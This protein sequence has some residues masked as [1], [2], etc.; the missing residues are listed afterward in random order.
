MS[1]C[2]IRGTS[3]PD[4]LAGTS[5]DDVICGL[6]GDD[7]LRGGGGK[8]TLFGGAG[9]DRLIGAAG[10]DHL[11]GGPGDDELSGGAGD[12]NLRGGNGADQFHG[13][14][15][16]D[17]G[18]YV[19]SDEAVRLSLG[20]GA[21]DGEPG[22]RDHIRSDVENLRGGSGNDTLR[23]DSRGNWLQGSPG[24]DRLTGGEGN[25]RLNGGAGADRL[26]GRDSGAFSDRLLCGS[27]GDQA[28]ADTD[29]RVGSD[30]E[31]VEQNRAPTDIVLSTASVPENEP[32]A[33]TVG[34]LSASD[35]NPGDTH[36]Y[37]LVAGVGDGDNGS[38]TVAGSALRTTAVFDFE[39]KRSYSLRVRVTDGEGA[40]FEKG[41]TVAVTDR[42]ENLSPVAVDD[43]AAATED[44]QLTLPLSGPGSPAANDTDADSNPLTVSAI[45]GA[46]GGNASIASGQIQF[47]PV[48]NLCGSGAAGFD[49]T[50]SDGQGGTDVGRVAVTIGCTPDDPIAVDDTATVAEDAAATTIDVL[51][52][53]SDPDGEPVTI[54]T[55]VQPANGTVVIT[56]LGADL[57]YLP[58]G[59]FCGA[60]S[61]TYTVVGGVTATVD[62]AV[63]CVNDAPVVTGATVSLAENSANGTAVHTVTFTDVEA[64]QGTFAI[65]SGDPDSAFAIDLSTGAI[66]VADSTELDFETTPSFNLT[67]QVTDD[68]TPPELGTATITVNL[69]DTGEPP[70]V[71]PATF[72]VAENAAAG[73]AVGSVT[74]TDPDAG[75]SHTFAITAGNTGGAFAINPTSGAITVA[76]PPNFEATP[77]YSLTVEVTDD[78]TPAPLSG[79]ATIT[80]NVTNVNEAPS[81][82]APTTVP[83]LRDVALVV[84]GIS[85]ADP[86]VG[87]IELT[88]AVDNGTIDVDETASTATVTGD[89]T[90]TIVITGTVTEINAILADANGVTYLNNAGFLGAT[91]SLH[92]DVDDLGTPPLAASATVT[93]QFNQPPVAA[94]L[95]PT[96]NEDTPVVVT[97]I[98]TDGDDDD[99]TF[100]ITDGPDNGSL[101]P[102]G[103]VDCTTVAN[104][105]T[106]PVTYTPNDD[107]NGADQFTY[108]V[109]DGVNTDT[110]TVNITVNSVNDV[111]VITLSGST[112]SYTENGASAAVDD[113]LTVADADDTNLVSGTVSVTAG[114]VAG[115]TLTFTPTG[116]IIDT[117]AAPDVLA[118][119][120][121]A[122]VADWQSVLRSIQFSSPSDNPT[123]ATRT[124]SFVVNDGDANS[125]TAQKSVAVVPV[126]DAAAI[127]T[128][129]GMLAYT[130][131]DAATVIDGGLTVADPDD[132][133]LEAARVLIS[134]GFDAGDTLVFVNQ[135]GITGVYNSAT[136]LLALTGTATVAQYQTALRSVAFRSTND[137]PTTTKTVEF[138]ADDGDGLGPPATRNIDVT[139]VND[140][141]AI[142][143]T[144]GNVA[145]TENAGPVAIDAGITV[146]DPDSA[147][148]AGATVTI[149]APG[150]SS[151]QDELDFTDQNGIT[152]TYNDTTG[153][154]T[155]SGT[156]SVANYQTA[157]RSVTYENV[158]DSPSASRT[159]SFQATDG[160]ATSNAATRGIAITSVND[161]PTAANDTASTDE[162]TI[163]NVTAPG[164]LANDTDVD[165]GDTKTVDRLNGNVVLTG[166]SAKGAAVTI[167]ANGS[168]SYNPGNIFQG[169]STGQSDTDS[170]TYRMS[171]SG[172]ASSTATVNLTII[173]VSDAPVAGADSFDGIGNTALSVGTARPTGEAGKVITGSVLTN[174][175]DV[176]T[177][178]A[179]LVAEAVTNAPTTLGGTITVE[180]DGNFTYH[181]DDGDTGVT[182]TFTYRVCD[183]T[184]CNSATV[185]NSTGTLSLPLAGQ[186][187]YVQNN[188]PAGGDGTS[189]TPFDTIG[190]AET[191]SGAG[192]TVYVFDGNNTS[193][194]LDTGFV[195]EAN[196][197]LIGE[198]NGVSLSGFLLHPGTA[199]AHPTLAASGEDVVVLA[200][201]ATVDG[202][203][204]D[205]A[206]AG[207][208][209][210]S[211]AL[212][213]VTGSTIND[214]NVADAGPTFGSQPGLDLDTTLGTFNISDLT[215]N[216]NGGTGV[217]LNAASIVNFT[218]ASTITITTAG[219][220]G[221]DVTNT[222]LGIS[223]FDN[224]TVT[225]SGSGGVSISGAAGST[226]TFQNLS[227]TTTSGTAPAFSLSSAG[228]VSVPGAGTANLSATGG[229]AVNVTGTA[230]AQ[231]A[232]DAVNSTNSTGAGINIAG[233]GAG[234]FT[235]TSGTIAGA[236]GIAF[237]LDGGSGT[238]TYPGPINDGTG[239]SADITNRSGGTVTLSGAITDGNDAGGGINL[240][241][242]TG[243]TINFTGGLTL[244]TGASLALAATA[245]GTVNVCA[246]N[247]CGGATAVVNTL[248]TTTGTALS[249]QNT[250]IGA[251][252]LTFRSISAGTAANAPANGIVLNS[253]GSAGGLTVT[254]NGGACTPGTPTCTGGTI[255]NTT[256]ADDSGATPPGTGVVLNNTQQ[257]SLT[258]MRVRQNTNYAIRG[259]DVTGFSFANGLID[260]VNGT[261]VATPFNDGSINLDRV[262][263]AISITGSDI[264]GGFQRNIKIDH[265]ATDASAT[266]TITIT[267]NS[268]HDTSASFGDDGI[269]I[270]AENADNY[271][272]NVSNNTFARHGGDHINVTMINNAVIDVTISNNTLSGGHPVGLGQGI[273][274]FG[275]SWNGTGT[276][277]VTNNTINGNRQGGAIHMNKG[278]GTA[279]MSGTISGNVIGTA[280][281]VGSGSAEAFGII[282]GSRGAGGS[283]TVL[284][285]SNTIRQY[286]DRGIV[287]QAGEGNA[288][289]NITVTNNT[290]TEFADAV[291][292]LHG[293]HLDVGI[294]STDAGSVCAD[295][296]GAGTARNN[297]TTAGNEPAGGVDIRVRRGS[298]M[299][300]QLRGYTGGSEDDAAVNAYLL[301]RND[302]TTVSATSPGTGTTSN[303]PGGAACATP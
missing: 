189:D 112:P 19:G 66:T 227:L 8:D 238:I 114:L 200:T 99:L 153:A 119:S 285:T 224:I 219:A 232:F 154:L 35:P 197:R 37:R 131:G 297:V 23:G 58:M 192:D 87:D 187:W 103:A 128:S 182:D 185:T 126:N 145:Y 72:T 173:G 191:A 218:P 47:D 122:T 67:V 254:G 34:T 169:L 267:G 243:S 139:P 51:A 237:D 261:N 104:T 226:T 85:V 171:D 176:D 146:V 286:F 36:A 175:T 100:S 255:Q 272:V 28:L 302:A 79:T 7:T 177:P 183:A 157:L 240:A 181:P 158:S 70:V 162:D 159:I 133:N 77:A 152:G 262:V 97:L 111:P 220:K 59:S 250:T 155:L 110:G 132:A 225:G 55:V 75:Q 49:Y 194:N 151:A 199:N 303:T 251:S 149:A 269:G 203:N 22:E 18:D 106:A 52:N 123:N 282:V 3:G 101:G 2:T 234:N 69:T 73:T 228:S 50:V 117:N 217:R 235:A 80:I 68:G 148:L 281:V 184:P 274:V 198:H 231:L 193:T 107:F 137:N 5:S 294:L 260:G 93:M 38:F 300:L 46:T 15:G 164:V 125:N 21:N 166:T 64:D 140:A 290:V 11:R 174:D 265:P 180:A 14:P 186:V 127:T 45:S 283:H 178:Q 263:G 124:V 188:E 102:I 135:N 252:G 207:G 248:T 41:L 215:V 229:P 271:T 118:L 160:A 280:G 48:A 279:T 30:C 168:F 230:G 150:F 40:T 26:D 241:S 216:T 278:S 208:G 1:D 239:Q 56:N 292:S 242:N 109:D 13:G 6:G 223:T 62:V 295:I 89:G 291:N 179:N 42:L 236:G 266:A 172:G 170:F 165:A 245:G 78:G 57:T 284:I 268:I 258:N 244:S 275:A 190:E 299:N 167:N 142:T 76:Q 270:E 96:T 74:F 163:L 88:L 60:D 296:G 247:P 39:G 144:A 82:T 202:I 4:A 94:D 12:D 210:G 196:E 71:N 17:L 222:N 273:L 32:P 287:A 212:N 257:V 116:G 113:G 108:E 65:T 147:D 105:C 20:D 201:G 276:Y 213:S 259:D 54:D 25:D 115:D 95:T 84:A 293:I 253:T 288:S 130:E 256:G 91:D 24:G 246:V 206:G 233:L 264:S 98:A 298:A 63:T 156:A 205:P 214:V 136:G 204:V 81:I 289:L 29:D 43:T 209:I 195:M 61:F 9:R 134:A 90:D 120:G 301:G 249:V 33:T 86:D 16:S 143:T 129:A 44:T 121:T 83:A 161:P 221:L 10:N 31:N 92:L 211:G 277:D 141:P 138:S 53:D 27:G